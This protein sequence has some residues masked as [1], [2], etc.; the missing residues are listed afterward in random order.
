MKHDRDSHLIDVY[1]DQ[2]LRDPSAS[3]PTELDAETVRMIDAL[4]DAE[5]PA[6]LSQAARAHMWRSALQSTKQAQTNGHVKEDAMQATIPQPR[7]PRSASSRASRWLLPLAAVFTALL[8][9]L[10]WFN[11]APSQITSLALASDTPTPA[12]TVAP[13]S[14]PMPTP[15][16]APPAMTFYRVDVTD[17]RY[18]IDGDVLEGRY[19][20][21]ASYDVAGYLYPGDFVTIIAS[22][23]D[24]AWLSIRKLTRDVLWIPMSA[25]TFVGDRTEDAAFVVYTDLSYYLRMGNY[26][27]LDAACNVH[28]TDTAVLLYDEPRTDSQSMPVMGASTDT[29]MVVIWVEAHGDVPWY[30]V[31]FETENTQYYGW[32]PSTDVEPVGG[33]CGDGMSIVLPSALDADICYVRPT[34]PEEGLPIWES[35]HTSAAPSHWYGRVFLEVTEIYHREEDDTLWYHVKPIRDDNGTGIDGWVRADEA[36]TYFV[37]CPTQTP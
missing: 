34:S 16:A 15:T 32:L 8:I 14:T 36:S 19:G 17:E 5:R 33:P 13:S 20:P 12:P 31:A 35:P 4:M 29:E 30:F 28:L 25:V 37:D 2:R 27:L 11:R 18:L 10:L 22:S 1:I 23:P 26:P 3:P 24:R 7:Q 6:V 9:G 21:G